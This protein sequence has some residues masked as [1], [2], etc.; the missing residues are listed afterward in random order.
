M[1]QRQTAMIFDFIEI[2]IFK[3]SCHL[4][5][6]FRARVYKFTTVI[7][8]LIFSLSFRLSSVSFRLSVAVAAALRRRRLAR[9]SVEK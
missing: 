2:S 6:L 4:F 3:L 7:F 8:F 5:V 1:R 9:A